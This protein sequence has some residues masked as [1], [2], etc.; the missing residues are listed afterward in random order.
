MTKFKQ[1]SVVLGSK[2]KSSKVYNSKEHPLLARRLALL[3]ITDA[4][5]AQTIG[6]R[7]STLNKWRQDHKEFDQAMNQ[8]GYIAD[9]KVVSKLF[10]RAM[11]V[12]RK[13][14]VVSGGEI[15]ELK[16]EVVPD[17]TAQQF[18]LERRRRDK[19]NKNS[20]VTLKGEQDNPLAFVMA[21]V[22]EEENERSPIPS[23]E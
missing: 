22:A 21:Q 11:G 12:T 19:W 1:N 4:E 15:Y 23:Q 18:W 9:S 5:I 17:V 3:G 14:E 2:E 10:D 16:E 13:K 6:I 20:E 7:E 8:G